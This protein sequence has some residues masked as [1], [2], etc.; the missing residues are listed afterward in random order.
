MNTVGWTEVG[1]GKEKWY[2]VKRSGRGFRIVGIDLVFHNH[3]MGN[4]I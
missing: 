1:D 2:E 4:N 3:V